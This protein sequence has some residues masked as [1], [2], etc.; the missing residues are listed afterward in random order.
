MS[1]TASDERAMS[2]TG[3][4]IIHQR[5]LCY[6][7]L[8]KESDSWCLEDALNQLAYVA[9]RILSRSR[10][11]GVLLDGKQGKVV[12]RRRACSVA[13]SLTAQGIHL[14]LVHSHTD[15]DRKHCN[16]KLV[17]SQLE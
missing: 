8:V 4:M 2:L 13:W 6:V 11:P 1:F 10:I 3:V 14:A 16:Q 12:A 9:A 17:V 5:N 7:P 15:M